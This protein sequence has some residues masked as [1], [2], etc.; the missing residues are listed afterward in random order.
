MIIQNNVIA[1]QNY[2]KQNIQHVNLPCHNVKR[3][4]GFQ[5]N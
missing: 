2:H 4:K 1:L 5:K 3:K